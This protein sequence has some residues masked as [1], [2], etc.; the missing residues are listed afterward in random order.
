MPRY[1]NNHRR[2]LAAGLLA[3][4]LAAAAQAQSVEYTLEDETG[5]QVASAPEPGSDAAV[6]ADVRRLLA[7][8]KPRSAR[9]VLT[10][11]IDL[12]KRTRSPLLP[13]AYLLRGDADLAAGREFRSLFDY[14]AVIRDFPASPEFVTAV[15]REYDIGVRYLNGLR[16]RFLGTFRFETARPT[17]EEL[18]IRVQER[19]PG[20]ALAERAALFLADHFYDRRE[21]DLAGEMYGIFLINYP[22]SPHVE[23]A[24]LRQIF[25][26]VAQF[27]GPAYD[28]AGL[29]EAR[30]LI[31]DYSARHPGSAD[32]G[33]IDGLTHRIDEAEAAQRLDT[34][35]W[36]LGRND[37][38]SARLTLRRLI[39]NHPRSAAAREGIAIM[40]DRGW[41][42]APVTDTT[43]ALAPADEASADEA[44][45]NEEPAS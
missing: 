26:N 24:R 34:A 23:H 12:N 30:L 33:V 2:A 27:K 44:P 40:T 8:G 42:D 41:M 4:S 1:A 45:P 43:D 39:R 36:Y 7:E 16:R 29:L 10:D 32:V 22:R 13:Q 11:W 19:L 9:A 3:L 20:S 38:P 28:G 6:I 15:E 31:E 17:G 14:E 35:M 21:L 37:E 5:W 18:L 25:C